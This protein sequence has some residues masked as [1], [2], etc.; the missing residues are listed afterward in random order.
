MQ[1][2]R[3][4]RSWGPALLCA[5]Q[6]VDVLGVTSAT[7]A[8]P[9]IAEE[10]TAGPIAVIVIASAYATFF[11]GFL[12]VG[13][14]FG[15]RWGHRRVLVIGLV[16]FAAVSAV[17]AT[18]TGAGQV[19]VARAVQGFAAAISIPSALRL[20]LHL[21]PEPVRRT[22]AIAAW[23]AAGAAAGAAGFL[24]GG[25]VTDL[26]SWRGI[27]W[28]NLP[29][30]LLLAVLVAHLIT[31][32]PQ[33]RGRSA[34]LDLQG[35][36]LWA[37]AVMTL[38][39]GAAVAEHAGSRLFGAAAVLLGLMLGAVFVL[40]QR[41]SSD[42][43][44]PPEAMGSPNLRLG[45]AVS[46]VNTATTSSSAVLLTLY[47]QQHHGTMPL[48]A[49][50]QLLPLNVAV[51]FGSAAAKSLSARFSR[52][53]LAASGLFAI[54]SGNLVLVLLS[55]HVAGVT[56]GVLLIGVGLGVAS[57]AATAIGTDV[58]EAI[59]GT[60]SGVVNTAAQ[61]GTAL[62]IA[63]FLAV[64]AAG[65]PEQNRHE[66]GVGDHRGHSRERSGRLRPT[67]NQ[68]TVPRV[69]G[70]T[71]LSKSQVSI[72][73]KDLDA[74]RNQLT[75]SKP[76]PCDDV[77]IRSR[78]NRTVHVD[79]LQGDRVG[80]KPPPGPGSIGERLQARR[81]LAG[82]QC[83]RSA[84]SAMGTSRVRARRAA[85]A[86]RLLVALNRMWGVGGFQF[87]DLVIIEGD[88]HAGECFG[89]L[90][91][92]RGADDRGVDVRLAQH[93]GERDAGAR[94]AALVGDLG[95]RLHRRL[96]VGVVR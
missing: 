70:I 31:D 62:G 53:R 24:L 39:G 17:G 91:R 29:I 52:P 45:S 26:W 48:Q 23:S 32:A 25:L 37:T 30:G 63:V 28:V 92:L 6:F 47:L 57:V 21:T 34:R 93:P 73:A 67:E 14:H 36:L 79:R 51:I 44:I 68:P 33:P 89:E 56:A 38:V 90:L 66:D 12:M 96:V 61:L 11:G 83:P 85:D 18:G 60:A 16:L 20:V 9:T 1:F 15:D 76:G 19:A 43:L 54:A 13:A 95:D 40:Q 78:R 46:F 27:F 64:A 69:L 86:W 82:R 58:P 7:T 65:T 94:H 8:I 81:C 59:A 75:G 74:P 77:P 71:R 2:L 55:R 72:M 41:R 88:V 42:A 50:L 49:G 84:S 35:A 22:S 3:L 4:P 80:H 87:L 10:L 5:V